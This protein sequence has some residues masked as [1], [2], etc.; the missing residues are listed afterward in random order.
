MLYIH[1]LILFIYLFFFSCYYVFQ[2]WLPSGFSLTGAL[3]GGA[4]V[5]VAHGWV[6]VMGGP[7][8]FLAR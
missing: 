4:M 7:V 3:L 8:R 6:A 5:L 2:S 1:V